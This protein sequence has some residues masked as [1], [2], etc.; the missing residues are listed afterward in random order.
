MVATLVLG[1]SAKAWGFESLHPHQNIRSVAQS[2]SAIGLGPMGR[3][4]E[5]LHSDQLL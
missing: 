1:T 4:F 3:E 2:G 5:S